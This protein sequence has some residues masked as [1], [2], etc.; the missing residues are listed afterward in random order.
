MRELNREIILNNNKQA[1]MLIEMA[2]A[3]CK[4]K[5]DVNEVVELAEQAIVNPDCEASLFAA[6]L[7]QSFLLLSTQEMYCKKTTKSIDLNRKVRDIKL[8]DENVTLSYEG[9]PNA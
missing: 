4:R 5:E 3:N 7:K 6:A 9:E 8:S 1:R 2:K